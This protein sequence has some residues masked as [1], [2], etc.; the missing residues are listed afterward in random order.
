MVNKMLIEH[1]TARLTTNPIRESQSMT[2]LSY[3]ERDSGH[4]R[5]SQLPDNLA[6]VQTSPISSRGKETSPLF[7]VRKEIGGL[8]AGY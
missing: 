4:L 8:H 6:C 1:K 5:N 3:H 7:R 2:A